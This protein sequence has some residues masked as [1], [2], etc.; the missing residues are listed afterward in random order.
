MSDDFIGK[1][2]ENADIVSAILPKWRTA[3]TH[4]RIHLSRVLSISEHDSIDDHGHD[5]G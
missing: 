3:K 2:A 1:V 4:V 5:L